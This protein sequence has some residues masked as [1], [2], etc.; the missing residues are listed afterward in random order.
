MATCSRCDSTG[1]VCEDHDDRPWD[2][3]AVRRRRHAMS[4]LQRV[5]PDN[6][7]GCYPDFSATTTN[8]APEEV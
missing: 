8:E 7:L 5:N 6:P 1:W 2:G 3:L 4:V